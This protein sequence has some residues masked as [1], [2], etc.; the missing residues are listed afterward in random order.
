MAVPTRYCERMP[1][2]VSRALS[3][4]FVPGV[5][6]GK[7][8][9]RWRERHPEV[10]LGLRQDEDPL[11][12]LRAGS[13]DVVF[14]RLPV[15]RTGLHLIPL[16]EEVP[17]VVMSWENELSLHDEVPVGELEGETLLDVVAC[18]SPATAVEVAA[19][20]AGVVVLPMSLARLHARKDAVHRPLEGAPGTT[21]GIAWRQ[22]D[23]SADVEEFVGIVRGRTAQS[24]RQPSQREAP[25]RSAAQ[26]AAAK[27]TA[28]P[29]TAS[30]G[31]KGGQRGQTRTPRP[32][33][34]RS[35][36]R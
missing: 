9:A 21:V 31:Q 16:Y 1:L 18:G 20:G 30:K 13:D 19:S 25:K 34:T 12:A 8:A 17:V 6:P 29:G 14:V 28:V 11:V 10:P 7:W 5:T 35:K 3:V 33:G 15:D 22:E 27:K 2:D 4:G 24:S 36:R 32:G 26:K 23:E